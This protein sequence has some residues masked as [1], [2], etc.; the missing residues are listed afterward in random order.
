MFSQNMDRL[1]RHRMGHLVYIARYRFQ[2]GRCHGLSC[3]P[4]YVR[5][6]LLSRTYVTCFHPSCIL[7]TKLIRSVPVYLGGYGIRSIHGFDMSL[8]FQPYGIHGTRLDFAQQR[9]S[10][11]LRSRGISVLL[12]IRPYHLT[13]NCLVRSA[14]WLHSVFNTLMQQSQVG[15]SCSSLKVSQP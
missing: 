3:L 8:Y 6:W 4:W 15:V 12:F 9:G 10:V 5:G 11:S 2:P 14:V 13:Q 7:L 1:R